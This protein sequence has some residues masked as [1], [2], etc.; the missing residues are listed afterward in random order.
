MGGGG[1]VIPCRILPKAAVNYFSDDFVQFTDQNKT[2]V[3]KQIF[4]K[5][6]LYI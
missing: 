6:S 3:I 2:E 5:N 1:I 4:V